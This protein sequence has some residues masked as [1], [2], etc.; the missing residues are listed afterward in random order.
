MMG[1]CNHVISA[2]VAVTVYVEEVE[3]RNVNLILSVQ[4]RNATILERI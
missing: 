2:A 3:E 4:E 1:F